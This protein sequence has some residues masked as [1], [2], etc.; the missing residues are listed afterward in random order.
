MKPWSAAR[1]MILAAMVEVAM[2]HLCDT[3]GGI[4]PAD[5]G[6]CQADADDCPNGSE[7]DS[8]LTGAYCS[9][10]PNT[11][12]CGCCAPGRARAT[13][14]S[15]GCVDCAN[16]RYSAIGDEE[17]TCHPCLSGKFGDTGNAQTSSGHCETCPTGKYQSAFA[18]SDC[19]SCDANKYHAL[20][21]QTSSSA[22]ANCPAGQTSAAGAS[23]CGGCVAGKF[24]AS[25]GACAVCPT[26]K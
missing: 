17:A 5:E 24:S 13:D 15:A 3:A 4:I 22:C 1:L 14:S 26:G 10:S 21:G 2:G 20:T 6:R 18:A 9:T 23:T 19:T 16:G 12:A 8:T 7:E 11:F 25:G